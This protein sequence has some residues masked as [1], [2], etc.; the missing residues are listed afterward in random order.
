MNRRNDRVQHFPQTS[1]RVMS[2]VARVNLSANLMAEKPRGK[3]FFVKRPHGSWSSM[4]VQL[5]QSGVM[6]TVSS[7]SDGLPS[8]RSEASQC[9][10]P[11]S[12]VAFM[13]FHHWLAPPT[14]IKLT[15]R[16]QTHINGW[17]TPAQGFSA[18]VCPPAIRSCSPST[19]INRRTHRP[20]CPHTPWPPTTIQKSLS[21][22]VRIIT[23]SLR[24][25]R[26]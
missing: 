17:G 4:D 23:V 7:P 3:S 8:V 5:P 11:S 20:A 14:C 9:C 12:H 25:R 24:S 6:F 21:S 13:A 10:P 18:T 22:S 15:L 16:N 19:I 2:R 1:Q 26:C